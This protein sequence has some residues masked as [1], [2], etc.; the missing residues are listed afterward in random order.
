MTFLSLMKTPIRTGQKKTKD[1][2]LMAAVE[3]IPLKCL[4]YSI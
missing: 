1:K 3:Q 4:H 2:S